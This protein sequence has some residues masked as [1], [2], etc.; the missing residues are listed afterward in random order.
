[1]SIEDA[2]LA[3]MLWHAPLMPIGRIQGFRRYARTA[4]QSAVLTGSGP[5]AYHRDGE[6][7]PPV[8]KLEVTVMPRALRVLVPAATVK[9]PAGPFSPAND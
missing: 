7:E 4:A 8:D 2:P 6:P 3:E 1:V 5:I 9:A